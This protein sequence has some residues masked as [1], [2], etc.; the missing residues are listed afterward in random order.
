MED[1]TR[2]DN[3]KHKGENPSFL[4]PNALEKTDRYQ[5]DEGEQTDSQNA[6]DEYTP[7]KPIVSLFG[8]VK[9]AWKN[10]TIANKLIAIF[11]GITALA[12]SIY[13]YLVWSQLSIM[14]HQLSIM[15]EQLRE[16]RAST[17]LEQRAWV[18]CKGGKC[19]HPISTEGQVN[20]DLTYS[21]SGKT[22]A[23]KVNITC[24]FI[25]GQKDFDIESLAN[26][27]KTTYSTEVETERSIAPNTTR[28]APWDISTQ[29]LTDE[30]VSKI[31][32]GDLVAYVFGK[33]TYDDVFGER[34]TTIYSYIINPS[35][36]TLKACRQHNRME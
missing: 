18:A 24:N 34:H 10:T 5:K 4:D 1:E 32:S 3:K 2:T 22:P 35:T 17:H 30:V 28:E 14:T 13:V 7:K 12:T 21:N 8:R 26:N 27:E 15:D 16:M 29:V 6:Q 11:T 33:I 19:R 25:I 31:K 36:W 9:R 20:I 23:N